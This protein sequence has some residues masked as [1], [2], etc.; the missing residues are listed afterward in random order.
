MIRW[1]FCS[2]LA[3]LSL[4]VVADYEGAV[5]LLCVFV[6]REIG[7]DGAQGDSDDSHAY[8][9]CTDSDNVAGD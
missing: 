6:R 3:V 4:R 8:V 9:F 7:P 1:M 5:E 2:S